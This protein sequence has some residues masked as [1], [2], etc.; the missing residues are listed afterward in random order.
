MIRAILQFCSWNSTD[1]YYEA[2]VELIKELGQ[3]IRKDGFTSSWD[4]WCEQ[5]DYD[6]NGSLPIKTG[7]VNMRLP[8]YFLDYDNMDECLAE[9]PSDDK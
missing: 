4:W 6:N 7:T 3:R 9:W 1:L 8:V 5:V 2:D